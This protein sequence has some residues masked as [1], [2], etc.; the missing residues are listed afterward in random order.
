ML[1]KASRLIKLTTGYF[2]F[3]THRNNFRHSLN[4]AIKLA[5]KPVV[6]FILFWSILNSGSSQ[7]FG[8]LRADLGGSV[9]SISFFAGDCYVNQE[10]ISTTTGWQGASAVN[11]LPSVVQGEKENYNLQNSAVYLGGEGDLQC[12]NYQT[13]GKTSDIEPESEPEENREEILSETLLATSTEL[14]NIATS[15]A[16]GDQEESSG[17]SS[18][19]ILPGTEDEVATSTAEM[20]EAEQSAMPEEEQGEKLPANDSEAML[21][22]AVADVQTLEEQILPAMLG[23]YDLVNQI[24]G[25]ISEVVVE[26]IDGLVDEVSA[27]I[28]PVALADDQELQSSKIRLSLSMQ[29]KAILDADLASATSTNRLTV[30]YSLS[31]NSGLSLEASS[32]EAWSELWHELAVLP[33]GASTS[34]ADIQTNFACLKEVLDGTVSASS[35]E[36]AVRQGAYY[37]FDAPF[38]A[39]GSD[40]KNLRIKISGSDEFSNF[41]TFLDSV[42]VTSAVSEGDDLTEDNGYAESEK[43]LFADQEIN[44]R[45]TDDNSNENLII[46]TD[47]SDYAGVSGNVVYFSVTN[48]GTTTENIKIQAHFPDDAGDVVSLER[49]KLKE[50]RAESL[51]LSEGEYKRPNVFQKSFYRVYQRKG[52]PAEMRAKKSTQDT[53]KLAPGKT[54]YFKMEISYPEKSSG[55]FYIEAEGDNEGYGLLD[56]W[57]SSS[58]LYKLPITINNTANSVGL[59]NYQ[60]LV[61]IAS[62]TAG[63]WE[64]TNA[65]GSDLRVMDATQTT[66]L[67]FWVQYWNKAGSSTQIWVQTD[68]LPA[69]ASTTIYLYYG[70]AS[71][72]STSDMYGTFSYATMQ[73]TYYVVSGF[74]TNASVTVTSLIDNNQVQLDNQTA[75]NLNRQQI[76]TFNAP[77]STSV[78]RVKGPVQANI[79]NIAGGA[80][81]VPISWA[82]KQFVMPSI[83]GNPEQFARYSPWVR[84]TTTLYNGN[85]LGAVTAIA[86]GTANLNTLNLT[87]AGRMT[88]T[89]PVLFYFY[90]STITYA[91]AVYPATLRDLYGIRSANNYIGFV[92]NTNFTINCS[93]G[94]TLGVTGQTTA[95]RYTNATC[96]TGNEG[97]GD[98]VRLS[99][100]TNPIGAI[101]QNDSDGTSQTVFLPD[102]ELSTEYMMN[103]NTAYIAVACAPKYGPVNLSIYNSSNVFV[104]SGTCTP[105]GNNPGKAYFG[106]ADVT[107]Y[108]AGSRIVATNGKPFYAYY[109]ETAVTAAGIERNFL[110][111][112]QA[113]KQASST[114]TYSIGDEQSSLIDI[115]GTVY[116]DD[117]STA[118]LTKPVVHLIKE[119]VFVASTTASP[120][121]GS[122][123]FAGVVMPETGSST[124]VFLVSS[125]VSG[126][127]YNRYSGSD[128]ITDLDIYQN[129]IIVRNGDSGPI[130]NSDIDEYDADQ[131]AFIKVQVASGNLLASSTQKLYIWTGSNYQPGGT[132]TLLAGGSGVGGS[133]YIATSSVFDVADNQISISGNWI[134][135]GS[136]LN[137]SA[138][139][140]NFSAT[141]TGVIIDNND[142]AFNHA[143]FAGVGGGWTLATGTIVSGNLL[144]ATGTLS[145]AYDLAVNGGTASGTGIMNLTGGTFT[146]SGT[147]EFGGANAWSFNNL[148]FGDG[149]SQAT[150]TKAGNGTTTIAGVLN[151]KNNQFVKAGSASWII[152]GAGTA[153]VASGILVPETSSF[154]YAAASDV[155]VAST[156]YYNLHLAPSAAGSPTYTLATGTLSTDNYLQIGDGINPVTVSAQANDTTL[157]IGGDLTINAGG[158]FTAAPSSNFTVAGSWH[159][160][161]TFNH[162]NG[163]VLFDSAT[164]GKIINPGNSVF[165]NISFDNPDGGWT[166]GQNATSSN[167]WSLIAGTFVASASIT[168]EVGG[169]FDNQIGGASTTWTGATL[170][171]KGTSG[172]INSKTAQAENYNIL[173]VG[174]NTDVKMWNSSASSVTVDPTGSLYSMDHGGVAGELGI[175]GDYHLL[176][177]TDYWSYETDF[178]GAD[179]SGAPRKA[180]VR[181]AT[182]STI[183][184]DGGTLNI[185]GTSS[186]KTTITNQGSGTYAFNVSAGIFHADYYEI[187]NTDTNG[188][189]FSG[190]P[191][192][193]H[194]GNGDYQLAGST[195]RAISL[196]ASVIDANPSYAPHDINFATTTAITS[197]FNVYLSGAPTSNWT[198][199]NHTGSFSGENY[200]SDPGD[201]AG[202]L[203]WDDSPVYSASSQNWQ[204]FTDIGNANPS[205]PAANENVAIE[206][207]AS[208]TPFKLRMT[209]KSGSIIGSNVKL[210]LQYSTSSNFSS[211]VRFVDEIGST[212]PWIYA[213]GV[214]ADNA[215]VTARVLTDSTANATH[216]E[217]GLSASTYTHAINTPAEW[218]FTVKSNGTAVPG[219]T[220]YFRLYVVNRPV[221]LETGATYPSITL[222]DSI[223][224]SGKVYSDTGTNELL[225]GQTVGLAV[226]NQIIGTTTASPI[227]GSFNFNNLDQ[228]A[229][230]QS[231]VI[232]LDN[233]E[234]EAPAPITYFNSTS[235]PVDAGTNATNPTVVTPPT[236][237]QAGDLVI[238]EAAHAAN[239]GTLAISNAGGQTWNALTQRVGGTQTVNLFWAQFNGTWSANPSVNMVSA[240]NNI[241]VMHVF[242]PGHSASS[243]AVDVPEASSAYAAVGT[244][245]IPSVITQ[246]DGAL[247]FAA[248]TSADDNTWNNLT[249]G[250]NTA[251]NAQYRNTSGANDQSVSSAYMVKTTAGPTGNVSLTQALL[252]PDAGTIYSIAFKEVKIASAY[253]TSFNRYA[254]TGDME[255]YDIYQDHVIVRSDYAGPLANN[256]IN[257]YDGD[258]NSQVKATVI[259]GNLTMP[260]SQMLY[261]WPG[262]TFKP[263]GQVTLSPG[264]SASAVG[265]DL[266]IG[267]GAVL[268]AES[269]NI[270]VGGDWINNGDLIFGA[271]QNVY[272][273]ATTSGFSITPGTANF[274]HLNFTGGGEWLFTDN[275][276]LS[277]D[278]NMASGTLSGT[279]NITVFGDNVT[280][281]GTINLTGGQFVHD[282]IGS[283][284]GANNWIFNDLRFGSSTSA[285]VVKSGG[286]RISVS[287]IL[288]VGNGSSLHASTSVWDLAGGTDPLVISGT[289]DNSSSTIRFLSNSDTNINA[290]DYYRLELTPSS[291]GSPI[292]AIAGG[293]LNIAD[294]LVIG[295]GAN[296]VTVNLNSNNPVVSVGGNLV[297]NNAGILSASASS[298]LN[299]G[300]NWSNNGSFIHND[301]TVVFVASSTGKTIS[302]GSSPFYK[303]AFNNPLG[304]WTMNQSATTTDNFSLVSGS[305]FALASGN[306]LEVQGLFINYLD[307]ASTTWTGSKLYING[308]SQVLNSK[309]D[310]GAN[311]GTVELGNDTQVKMWNSSVATGT[312]PM[313]S[314]LYSMDNNGI[315][316]NLYVWGNYAVATAEYWSYKTDFDGTD[317]TATPR[318]ARIFI[319]SSSA[320]S[321]SAATLDML[322]ASTATTTVANQGIG[323]YALNISSST[324]NANYFQIRNTDFQ[325][326]NIN[327][328][329]TVSDLSHGDFLL[330]SSS[331]ALITLSAEA[332]NQTGT[333]S[334]PT[335]IFA[336]STGVTTGYNVNLSGTPLVIWDFYGSTGNF[337]S[338]NFDNDA[339]EPRGNLLWDDSPDWLPR[340]QNWQWFFDQDREKPLSAAALENVAPPNIG[341][342]NTI[343]LRLTV[344]EMNNIVGNNAK[345]RL[346]YSTV[347]DFSSGVY[348]VSEIGSTTAPWTYGEGI[349][350]DNDPILETVLSDSTA[351]STHNE[352]G[353]STSDYTLAP[354]SSAEWEFTLLA[355]RAATGTIYYFRAFANQQKIGAVLPNGGETYPSLMINQNSMVTTLSGYNTGAVLA[356]VVVDATSTPATMPFGDLAFGVDTVGAQQLSISTNAESGYQL[357]IKENQSLQNDLGAVMPD[358]PGDNANPQAWPVADVSAFGYHTSDNTLSGANPSRFA[359]DNTYAKF[360]TAMQ[361]VGYSAV[362]VINDLIN[363]IYRI[364]ASSQQVAG[365]YQNTIEYIVVPTY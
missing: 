340:S 142:S 97:L 285:A 260:A 151:L 145:S 107:T 32:S 222:L 271:N 207:I 10:N 76:A 2:S 337:A 234:L 157:D 170:Y 330:A 75:V 350:N 273:T 38:I 335:L 137:S 50:N 67:P 332:M 261:V 255:N 37:I 336:S 90:G 19:I 7:L 357:L 99:A 100:Q 228:F 303:V 176:A 161:G 233:S 26:K 57:W 236:G 130:T 5:W 354:N 331:Y 349:D 153:F 348:D 304:G 21:S 28:E 136:F 265:G 134:N 287:R 306:T 25:L 77:A 347:S 241:V 262:A 249:G 307:K 259:G 305:Q 346:Q 140:T 254:G 82:G 70:N 59:T 171:L 54:Q 152:N 111:A 329:S 322:G 311:F 166:V 193:T 127:T 188:L 198:F 270:N 55:E 69:S 333:S 14:E 149:A 154:R 211:D 74:L 220:Y 327:G 267:S 22:Q 8:Q 238:L 283:F 189:N 124:M 88:A 113:R 158:I 298:N 183:S 92:G 243:W 182:S 299:V 178:D 344:K 338:E 361:E 58:W 164:S 294:Y 187:K 258:Q 33:I 318:P 179:L 244:V 15:T 364:K 66:S 288:T 11:G 156:S 141:G 363:I 114:P 309:N 301:G 356:G 122:Y 218:E 4:D 51:A 73:D 317:I 229:T 200:D 326:L 78:L 210:R 181:L 272:F 201:P 115:S 109:E 246:T 163:A 71:A 147:G 165:Y 360:E 72:A 225:S 104:T 339:S 334:W 98:A 352:S 355:N 185:V 316:G 3:L 266:H 235:T 253:G 52:V 53:V 237:M 264:N 160:F 44:F 94:A 173:K 63:F 62:T 296:P 343:K 23:G 60:V 56:P 125:T 121:D 278:L 190:T 224:I 297:I 172:L 302:A 268:D 321:I 45:H 93:G 256:D 310:S 132:V 358:V 248:W 169:L 205:A 13:N 177:G 230:G 295:N 120:T 135:D 290:L 279:A 276:L 101:Q 105:S 29:E 203:L 202:Y 196:T 148:A 112:V 274:N 49:L 12:E 119:G 251:G 212:T 280:G 277:G 129:R 138:Q 226:G 155:L 35:S 126:V 85:T 34:C 245:T 123:A 269:F 128:N 328:S 291:A 216:N 139:I 194:L 18:E 86:A 31:N 184:V 365:D 150:T 133:I 180:N 65:D 174:P 95:A 131:S 83:L 9:T 41:E 289:M 191:N 43:I 186:E 282:G 146:L 197:A 313:T 103:K 263:G 284:G 209:V 106:A 351:T 341:N 40:I 199:A 46:K 47:H 36:T 68:S 314:S 324:L 192:I 286:N 108:N 221:A 208:N 27:S 231:T 232:F 239:T 247:V 195:G 323:A 87:T 102:V 30:W 242:R 96:V 240:I 80:T 319:A 312:V 308:L 215:A 217:S 257:N 89:D 342:G 292:Y 81:V 64:H 219:A 20:K 214:D 91:S 1:K 144:M 359:A 320:V 293:N 281:D 206:R 168:V 250:W 252:G 84:A 353:T 61:E 143:N 275:A 325:G 362:P 17:T 116:A 39:K 162:S 345:L 42:W 159:N 24:I 6:L 48:I 227:D 315:D 213:N 110:G 79:T 16:Q 223:S 167:N 118:L 175:W 300:G 117:G 204:W